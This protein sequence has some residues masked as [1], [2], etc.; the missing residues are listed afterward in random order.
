MLN[1]AFICGGLYDTLHRYL[2][3]SATKVRQKLQTKKKK[4]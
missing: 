3:F 2:H 1:E 4:R